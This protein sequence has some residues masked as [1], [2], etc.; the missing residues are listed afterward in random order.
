[1]N[2]VFIVLHAVLPAAEYTQLFEKPKE[3]EKQSSDLM[4]TEESSRKSARDPT[5]D[6]LDDKQ[7]ESKKQKL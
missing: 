2:F 7:L 4:D 6:V 5:A 1:L 3:Q